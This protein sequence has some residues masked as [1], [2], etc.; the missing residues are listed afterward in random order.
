M[1]NILISLCL[2]VVAGCAV[3]IPEVEQVDKCSGW[4]PETIYASDSK[5]EQ[6]RKLERNTYMQGVCP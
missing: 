5:A 6:L 1:R 3:A 4:T 2:W